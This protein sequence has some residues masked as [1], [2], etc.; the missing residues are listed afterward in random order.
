MSKTIPNN[1]N[2]QYEVNLSNETWT[3]ADGSN[4]TNDDGHG[5]HEGSLFHDNLIKVD[6]SISA[7]SYTSAGVA[8]QGTRSSV[9][10]GENGSIDA[11]HGV[12]LFGDDQAVVNNGILNVQGMGLASFGDGNFLTNNGIIKVHPSAKNDVDG[13]VAN[14]E[15][16]VF[17][18]ASGTIDV[19]G[20]GIV[21]KSVTGEV[22]EVTNFGSVFAGDFAFEGWGGNE[23]LVNRGLMDGDI[24]M[25]SGNDIFDGAGGSVQGAV[26][27]GIGDD[28]YIIDSANIFLYEKAGEGSDLVQSK[29]SWTLAKDFENLQLQGSLAINGKGNESANILTGNAKANKLN[30]M[31]NDDD[32]DGGNGADALTGGL[33]FDTFH[34]S[35]G[36]GKDR[37]TDYTDGIDTI[38]LSGLSGVTDFFDLKK[39]HM[40]MSGDDLV[41]TSGTDRLIIEDTRKSAMDFFDFDF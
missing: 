28:T 31:S 10:V 8:I 18:N 30:G 37:I 33:G 7:L 1:Y 4:L 3:L 36:Y 22:T 29:A 38:D 20:R 15:D 13:I 27:G 40:T 17:N 24:Q 6:G 5:I 16:F 39:N 32:L 2:D 21:V 11:W 26:M 9:V 19:T 41:I 23:K 12:E 35:S 25:G 14:G 34:F